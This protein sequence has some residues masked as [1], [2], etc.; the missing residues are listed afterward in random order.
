M[1]R[2]VA[3]PA[4]RVQ[5]ETKTIHHLRVP[6]QRLTRL[7]NQNVGTVVGGYDKQLRHSPQPEFPAGGLDRSIKLSRKLCQQIAR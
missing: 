7:G 5:I 2:R 6:H 1:L 3:K 4:L